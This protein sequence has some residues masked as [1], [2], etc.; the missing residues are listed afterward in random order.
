MFFCLYLCS[1][2][3]RFLDWGVPGRERV[4]IA[5]TLFLFVREHFHAIQFSFFLINIVFDDVIS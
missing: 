5:A 4:V 2:I 3:E 1:G